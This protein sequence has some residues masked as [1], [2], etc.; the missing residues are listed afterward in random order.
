MPFGISD[1]DQRQWIVKNREEVQ[2]HVEG[3]LIAY[4]ACFR[5]G[6]YGA[7]ALSK[8]SPL[9]GL[10]MN[11]VGKKKAGGLPQNF[12]VTVTDDKVQA[13]KYRPRGWTLK[14]GH[15]VATWDRDGITASAEKTQ[16]TTRVTLEAP[17][18]DEKIVFDTNKGSIGDDLV[19]ALIRR[20]R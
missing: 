15:E 8:A 5:T 2:R 16:M 1:D 19:A 3:E 10:V 9:A 11:M 14:L 20:Q 13:F 7:T 12:V 6:S 4:C 18:D 17:G